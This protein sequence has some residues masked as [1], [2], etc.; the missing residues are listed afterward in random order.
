MASKLVQ[1]M[2]SGVGGLCFRSVCAGTE[3]LTAL[4]KATCREYRRGVP[5]YTQDLTDGEGGGGRA[6]LAAGATAHERAGSPRID[7]PVQERSE[8]GLSFFRQ[9]LRR[10]DR[11]EAQR[12]SG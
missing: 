11:G 1:K 8:A 4:P 9:W 6:L 10:E 3:A 12:R 2:P 7:V 5:G